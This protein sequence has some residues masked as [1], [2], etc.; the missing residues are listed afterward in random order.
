MIIVR[1]LQFLAA[2]F[3]IRLIGRAIT[4][5]LRSMSKPNPA[6]QRPAGIV[7][8]LVHDRVC[9]VHVP[10]DRALTAKIEGQSEY[11]CSEKCRDEALR[12]VRKAS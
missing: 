9:N 10:R 7:A 2:M 12:T 11:F 1:F 4:A 6:A 5:M 8:E 3:V